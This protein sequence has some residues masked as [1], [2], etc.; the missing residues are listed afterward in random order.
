M[1]STRE[2]RDGGNLSSRGRRLTN[3][4]SPFL[5]AGR[6]NDVSR[7]DRNQEGHPYRKS[8]QKPPAQQTAP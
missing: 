3:S 2:V 4:T 7:W 6:A 1:L 8:Y 5:E